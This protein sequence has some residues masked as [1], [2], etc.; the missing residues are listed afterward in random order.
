ERRLAIADHRRTGLP[1]DPVWVPGLHGRARTIEAAQRV[2]FEQ[3]TD[4]SCSAALGAIA[5]GFGNVRTGI[6]DRQ[7]R[8]DC[9]GK[10]NDH[11]SYRREYGANIIIRASGNTLICP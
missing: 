11:P 5:P 3:T 4:W 9:S 6:D 8:D 1:G 7:W 2:V 10:T